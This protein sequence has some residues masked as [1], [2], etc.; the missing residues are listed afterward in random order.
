MITITLNPAIDV[1]YHLE[2]FVV[3]KGYRVENGHKTA[4]GKGLNVSRVLN[5]LGEKPVCTGFLGGSNGEW[6]RT[7][8]DKQQLQDQFLPIQGETR[9]CLAILDDSAGT[10][11]EL[12]EKGP[13]IEEKEATA[14]LSYF[15]EALEQTKYV[16]ASGSLPAGLPV[17]FYCQLA[18]LAKERDVRF[19]LDTSGEVLRKGIEGQPFLIKP[20]DEELCA[21]AN[22]SS[23]TIDEMIAVAKQLCT[24][25]VGNVLLSLG[26]DGALLIN[27]HQV[28]KASIPTV[29]AI[30]PVGSGD[31]MLAGMT[32]ALQ[33][34]KSL[35]DALAWACACGTANAM[36]AQT[37]FVQLNHVHD[38]LTKIQITT[39]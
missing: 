9:T 34:G 13:T 27:E 36:E 28:I 33:Q 32:H 37:G 6:I 29:E 17:D 4:G 38:L 23:L 8:L 5:I 12:L 25:G 21:Y 11:T 30:N 10:Q 20:N 26:K 1:S 2:Q 19:V 24:N 7:Q 39:I 18:Q 3:D 35:E 15:R 22:Q 31:S 16:I 14:F